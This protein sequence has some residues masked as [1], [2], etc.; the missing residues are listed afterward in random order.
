MSLVKED[1]AH[2]LQ[3]YEKRSFKNLT[4]L[5]LIV[6]EA[7]NE[8]VLYHINQAFNT[9]QEQV[10]AFTNQTINLQRE[11]NARDENIGELRHEISSLIGKLNE[12]EKLIFNRNTE[13]VSRLQQTIKHLD[14]AKE[15]EEKRLK[16]IISELQAKVDAL[17]KE[18]YSLNDKLA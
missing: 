14:E 7:P 11:I 12:Q 5:Y 9:C 18:K 2:I 17:L 1:S 16:G 8:A 10:H 13:E 3:F 15:M 4:H 6:N